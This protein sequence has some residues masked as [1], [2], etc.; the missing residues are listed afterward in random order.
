MTT[1][2]EQI[3]AWHRWNDERV[4]L[5][6]EL[7]DADVALGKIKVQRA[8]AQ[9]ALLKFNDLPEPPHPTVQVRLR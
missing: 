6:A 5:Q 7:A 4:R 1:R 3:E 8:R 2:D 9:A